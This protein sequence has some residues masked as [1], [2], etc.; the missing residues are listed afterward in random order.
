LTG[1]GRVDVSAE[2]RLTPAAALHLGE[3]LPPVGVC[4]GYLLLYGRR[5]RE[6]GGRRPASWRV[7]SFVAGVVLVGAVQLPPLDGVADTL[8]VAHMAQHIILGEV[9]S[10]LIVLGLTG[11]MLAPLLRLGVSR[12]LRL[13]SRPMTALVLWTADLYVWHLPGLYQLAIRHD[14]VHALQ[15]ACFLWFG[16]LLWLALLG[17]LPKPAWFAGWGRIGYVAAVRVTG[18]ILAN[19]LIWTQDVLYPVYRSADAARGIGALSDQSLAGGL[20]MLAQIAITT[21]LL[22]WLFLELTRREEVRQGLIDLAAERGASLSAERAARAAAAGAGD[23]LRARLQGA[24][25]EIEDR[26]LARDEPG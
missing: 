1:R 5:L 22:A 23:R 3:F 25:A 19:V 4:A 26:L 6:L 17:P 8:L 20:M 10:L 18:A 24:G 7:A 15:H 12:P 16:V 14:L 13:L 2:I 21:G 11:P 9:A